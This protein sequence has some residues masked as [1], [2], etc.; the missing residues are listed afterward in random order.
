[1]KRLFTLAILTLLIGCAKAPAGCP[2]Y[3]KV[4]VG[5]GCRETGTGQFVDPIRCEDC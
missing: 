5:S 1:M 2:G 3:E 4:A